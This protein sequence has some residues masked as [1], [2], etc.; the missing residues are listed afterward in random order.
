MPKETGVGNGVGGAVGV[1]VRVGVDVGVG[2]KTKHAGRLE[3][4][5]VTDVV[6]IQLSPPSGQREYDC[7]ELKVLL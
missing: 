5:L 4:F 7:K 1:G 3:E 6:A 2:V